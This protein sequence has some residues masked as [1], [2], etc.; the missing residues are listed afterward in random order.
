MKPDA[1]LAAEIDRIR[2]RLG[3]MA[4]ET[5]ALRSRLS[6]L[7]AGK[8]APTQPAPNST[9]VSSRS[10]AP[11]KLALFRRLFAGRQDVFAVR[12]E[13]TKTGK[14]GYA[15]AC[16][17]EWIKGVCG[18]PQVKCGECPN[19]AFLPISDEAIARHLG[20][21]GAFVIGAYAL[22]PGDSEKSDPDNYFSDG[23]V[24]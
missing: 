16:R 15:P 13:N 5:E 23:P 1:K 20:G 6:V 24:K 21:D 22:V 17:N 11:R 19:Q 2:H 4:A 12:W 14:S 9:E 8:A 3:E 10:P 7:E 18:K